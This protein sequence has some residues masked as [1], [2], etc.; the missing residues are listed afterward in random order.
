MHSVL[1][2]DADIVL[3]RTD[4]S[5]MRDKRVL[6]TGASGL[7][8]INLVSCIKKMKDEY[9]IELWCWFREQ[10]DPCFSDV[11]TDCNIIRGDITDTQMFSNLPQF[12]FIIHSSGYAQ[13]SKF[14]EDKIKTI[15]LNTTSTIFLLEKLNKDGT[16]LFIS[17]SEIYSGLDH[18]N[19]QENE[20][21]TTNT[22]HPRSCYIEGKRTGEAI[23]HAYVQ[24]GYNIKIARLS[25][26]YGA[27]AKKNDKRVLN[28][29]IDRGLTEQSI[30]LMDDGSAIRTFCYISDVTEMLFTIMLFGKDVTYNIGGIS[31]LSIYELAC[32][33]GNILEKEVTVPQS[34]NSMA[35]NPKIVNVSIQRYMDEFGKSSRNF[36]DFDEGLNRTIEWQTQFVG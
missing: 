6:V 11:F 20:V 29:L 28:T 27:G 31:E 17:T 13:P 19:I 15:Q 14:L 16:F 2:N 8:G 5:K 33:I 30:K 7:V 34:S 26:A 36:V 35:G 1:S 4:L 32:K 24:R 21:G 9:N 3:S 22:D 12:D 23:C 10:I 18:H 25:S